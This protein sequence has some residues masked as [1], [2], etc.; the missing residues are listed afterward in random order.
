MY[1]PESAGAREATNPTASL[2]RSYQMSSDAPPR[3]EPETRRTPNLMSQNL[4]FDPPFN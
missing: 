1:E 2:G 3:A 4:D